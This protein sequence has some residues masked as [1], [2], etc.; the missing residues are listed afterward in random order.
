M[1]RD[2][3]FRM[4]DIA[5]MMAEIQR[6]SAV[7]Q[8]QQTDIAN[9]NTQFVTL[10]QQQATAQNLVTYM[11]GKLTTSISDGFSKGSKGSG[12]SGESG[13][14]LVDTR[15]ISKPGVFNNRR[16]TWPSWSFRLGNFLEG[17]AIGFSKS[18]DRRTCSFA[19]ACESRCPHRR[20]KIS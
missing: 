19:G 6:L 11:L 20:R 1:E 15:G 3:Y 13:F 9:A 10:Q 14:S 4:G 8:Q 17:A 5:N 7:V 16:D 12:K 2:L 18:C